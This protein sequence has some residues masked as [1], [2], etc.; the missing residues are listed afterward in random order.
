MLIYSTVAILHLTLRDTTVSLIKLQKLT[1]IPQLHRPLVSIAIIVS[2]CLLPRSVCDTRHALARTFIV[3][4]NINVSSLYEGKKT[5]Q[6]CLL[7]PPD[8]ISILNV[9]F[10]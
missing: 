7:S 5:A 9:I 4:N 6:K 1:D 3:Y 2:V 8:K 10:V